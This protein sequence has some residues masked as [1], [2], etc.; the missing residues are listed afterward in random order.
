MATSKIYEVWRE[1]DMCEGR[2]GQI[3]HRTFTDRDEAIAYMDKQIGLAGRQPG[4]FFPGDT[5]SNQPGGYAWQ[6][7]VYRPE[8]VRKLLYIDW[9][10]VEKDV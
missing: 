4:N 8:M 9:Y 1:K 2:E 10:L 6:L 5:W 3:L 7:K